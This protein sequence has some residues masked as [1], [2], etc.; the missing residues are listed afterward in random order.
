MATATVRISRG[1]RE[2][3]RDLAARE[4]VSMPSIL[5]RAIEYYRRKRFLDEANTAFAALRDDTKEWEAELDERAAWEETLAD[6][7]ES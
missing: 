2:V 1:A 4:G 6:G 5:E 7:V 3:L